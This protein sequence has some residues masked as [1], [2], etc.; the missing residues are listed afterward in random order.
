MAQP[1]LAPSDLPLFPFEHPTGLDAF[2]LFEELR[3]R[4]P[5]SP[6]RLPMGGQA[7]V[8]ARYQDLVAR[9]HGI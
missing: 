3:E 8:V 5:V 2:P 1:D 6:V 9:M 7:F 4:Q